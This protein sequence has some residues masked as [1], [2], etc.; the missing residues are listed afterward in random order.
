MVAALWVGGEVSDVLAQQSATGLML[1]GFRGGVYLRFGPRIIAVTGPSV[2]AGPLN[3]TLDRDLDFDADRRIDCPRVIAGTLHLGPLELRG[4]SADSW[5]PSH[6]PAA[7]SARIRDLG[8]LAQAQAVP[9]ELAAV[10][11]DVLRAID[12]DLMDRARDLLGGRGSGLTPTGDDVLA[13]LVL[14]RALCDPGRRHGLVELVE[15]THTSDLSLRFLHWAGRGVS[16]E[17]VHRLLDADPGEV[18]SAAG[19]V[20]SVGGSSGQALLFGMAQS[21]RLP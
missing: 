12:D 5:M 13:G 20:C 4:P 10:W 11:P 8:L 2:P 18:S 6:G 17:P 1:G 21:S 9:Q 19:A 14:G 15:R 16:I 3:L 7:V